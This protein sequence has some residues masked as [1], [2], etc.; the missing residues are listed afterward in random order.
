MLTGI[1]LFFLIKLSQPFRKFLGRSRDLQDYRK[2]GKE[3]NKV[4]LELN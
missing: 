2:T 3:K 4:S 1:I